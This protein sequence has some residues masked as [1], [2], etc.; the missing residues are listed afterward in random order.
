LPWAQ[1]TSMTGRACFAAREF[2]AFI[3]QVAGGTEN[4]F[5][6]TAGKGNARLECLWDATRPVCTVTL[7]ECR[8]T[9]A[10]W[11]RFISGWGWLM[12]E[13][14]QCSGRSIHGEKRCLEVGR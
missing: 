13:G 5:H 8:K 1:P 7:T 14:Q 6:V 10:G 12:L 4:A 11:E 2:V 9:V 3:D